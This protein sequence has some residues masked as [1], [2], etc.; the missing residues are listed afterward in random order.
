MS[1]LETT[2]AFLLHTP[3]AKPELQLWG[4]FLEGLALFLPS[5][6]IKLSWHT[7]EI[8]T[9]RPIAYAFA[10]VPPPWS[11]DNPVR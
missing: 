8:P 9:I 11:T 2:S 6:V 4:L 10:P 3:Q 7:I 1:S 5:T